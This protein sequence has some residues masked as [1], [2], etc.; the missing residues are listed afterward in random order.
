[1][2]LLNGFYI[3]VLIASFITLFNNLNNLLSPKI[4]VSLI[5]ITSAILF[6]TK[7]SSFYFLAIIWIIVQIP[8]LKT[9]TF[10]LDLSQ[11][12]NI[13]FSIRWG[14]FSIGINAQV[15]LLIFLKQISLSEFLFKKVT[16]KAYTENLKLK[17][18]NEYSFITTDIISKKLIGKSEI[19]IENESYSKVIFEPQKSER[20]KKAGITLIPLNENGKIKATI[21]YKMNNNVW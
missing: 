14:T 3:F 16:F 18:G 19:E 4:I 8:Y 7:K 9:D 1:M 5:G 13:H 10:T 11:F 21:E 12:L 17:R 15:L 20:I 2:K 6:F